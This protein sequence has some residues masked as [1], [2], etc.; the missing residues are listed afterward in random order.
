MLKDASDRQE[1]SASASQL[2]SFCVC[3]DV[4]LQ[5]SKRRDWPPKGRR[6]KSRRPEPYSIY[7]VRWVTVQGKFLGFLAAAAETWVTGITSSANTSV[8]KGPRRARS[9]VG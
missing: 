2:P 9:S 6:P 7:E 4:D 1:M 5:G 3:L 8:T